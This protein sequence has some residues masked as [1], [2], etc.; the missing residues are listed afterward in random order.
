M[1]KK[2][3][4][5][6]TTEERQEFWRMWRQGKSHQAI[7]TQM[8]I[9]KPSVF[10]YLR[11]RGGIEPRKRTRSVIVLS[12]NEREEISRGLGS[13]LSLRQ[14]ARGLGRSPSTISREVR[15][16]GGR[17]KYRAA[18]ADRRAWKNAC[19]PKPSRLSCNERLR[20]MVSEKLR[21]RWSPEQIAAWLRREHADDR[22]LQVSHETIYKSLF[23][24]SRGALKQELRDY[25]RTK[26]RFR[27]ARTKTRKGHGIIPDPISIRERPAEV[28]DRA[29]PGHWE[30]DLISG[31]L[32]FSH[33]A[34]LVERK[35]RYVMLARLRS[36]TTDEVTKAIA[37]QIKKL[38][39]ELRKSLT[40]D[41]G[42]E[43]T[44]H[45]QLTL[46]ANID[47]YFCDPHS[48]WQR[49][50]NENTNGLLRQYFPKGTDL[51]GHSQ[52]KLDAVARELNER[53]RKTL[54]FK[55]PAAALQQAFVEAG[56]APIG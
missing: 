3:R 11:D 53:P 22:R 7:A 27:Q 40:W 55:T 38:P 56:V 24:Q 8:G 52:R 4:S 51:S 54:G 29:I 42:G 21:K 39:T 23:I 33:I 12:E 15:R 5:H 18:A 13:G 49:G 17:C 47:I 16:H 14:I 45:K 34:T 26:R 25:L 20:A 41:N 37:R 10:M 48:P 19:R 31:E 2:R 32:N 36:K 6:L 35:T 9:A 28:E 44:N 46:D 1:G 50:S 43:L 30:G